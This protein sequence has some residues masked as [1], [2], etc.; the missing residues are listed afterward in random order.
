MHSS[1]ATQ[2]LSPEIAEKII[3]LEQKFAAMGQD[4]S[5]YLDGLLHADYLTYWDYIK[6][7]TLLSLQNPKTAFPDE[8]IFIV[9]HQ[10]T[11]LYFKLVLH[12]MSQLATLPDLT[13]AFFAERLGRINRYF[14]LLVRSQVIMHEGMDKKQFLNFRMSLLP[15]S[16][17]QSI[18]FRQ[19]EIC[20]T[21][22]VRLADHAYIADLHPQDIETIYEH[23]YWK[24]GA[25]E[26]ATQQKTLTLK[27]FEHKYSEELIRLAKNY[28][29][30]NL[31][32]LYCKLG[33]PGA[34]IPLMRNF[35]QLVNVHWR[36]AHLKSAVKY[37]QNDPNILAATGGTNWQK[38]LPPASQRRMF[39]H[40]LWSE[41]EK[42]NWGKVLF[43]SN[44]IDQ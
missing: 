5:S 27:Q 35:D 40:E 14:E 15:S 18:Q 19:I 41:E 24:K 33:S 29:D 16:G 42:Q 11:E 17:F 3:L 13:E 21:P 26:I 31:W 12:E 36:L 39:F 9:Y 23:I 38:Y 22:F 30:C 2:A 20:A 1:N 25:T 6:L 7:D 34:L 10:A 44:S 4:M 37:L 28:A 32:V 8:H 43:E